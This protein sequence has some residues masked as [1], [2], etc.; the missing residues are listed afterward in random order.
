ML[1]GALVTQWKGLR[2]PPGVRGCEES[3]WVG[4]WL[5]PG[6]HLSGYLLNTAALH[7]I[8]FERRIR[9]LKQC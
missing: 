2:G 9:H 4:S 7:K 3:E 8:L 1:S 6:I 5:H